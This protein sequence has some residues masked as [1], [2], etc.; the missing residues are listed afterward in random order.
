MALFE[1][2]RKNGEKFKIDLTL[3]K[4]TKLADDQNLRFTMLH[5][6]T[7]GHGI[8]GEDF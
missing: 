4:A 2:T 5:G 7:S 6:G 8:P 3:A 1:F